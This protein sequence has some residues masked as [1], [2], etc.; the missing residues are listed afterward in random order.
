MATVAPGRP[1]RLSDA[2]HSRLRYPPPGRDLFI[3]VVDGALAAPGSSL[4]LA[5]HVGR[6][7]L[8]WLGAIDESMLEPLPGQG[9]D[10]RDHI[11]AALLTGPGLWNCIFPEE[12]LNHP[13]ARQTTVYRGRRP[14]IVVGE[15]PCGDLMAMPL[16]DASGNPKPYT[17]VIPIGALPTLHSKASQ[18]EIPHLW[19]LPSSVR[20]MSRLEPPYQNTLARAIRIYFGLRHGGLR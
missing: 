1:V 5:A 13:L 9:Y 11:R 12:L 8:D 10:A 20:I 3:A 14:W 19:S 7:G 16:N 6:R 4:T 2:E 18:L 17:P 15:L